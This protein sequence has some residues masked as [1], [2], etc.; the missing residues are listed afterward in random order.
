MASSI[1][2]G[3]RT[4]GSWLSRLFGGG[5]RVTADKLHVHFLKRDPGS[6]L[7]GYF[8]E[9]A[10]HPPLSPHA[11]RIDAALADLEKVGSQPLWEKYGQPEGATR[12][13][14]MVSTLY[15]IGHL[16]TDLV[17]RRKPDTVVE[18]G[19]AFGVS[20]MYWLSGLE[21]NGRGKLY[22][23]EPNDTWRKVAVQNLERIGTRFRSVLGTFEEH[24]EAE[25]GQTK[26]DLAFIDAIHTS[27][28]VK[29]QFERVAAKLAPRGLIVLDDIHFSEDMKQCWQT[30]A[31][32]PRVRA[33]VALSNQSG[34]VEFA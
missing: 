25:L 5:K 23:F 1:R 11:D 27:E 24:V 14:E 3:T 9:T 7:S 8:T 22:T 19:T 18:F 12:T 33:S 17:R 28:W 10:I 6:W 13:P 4:T 34:I 2:G 21:A 26:I 29:P 16:Y 20:G 30:L 32:D 31:N 15:A